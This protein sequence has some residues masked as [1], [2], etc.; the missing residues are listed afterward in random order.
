MYL[1]A[2][3][4]FISIHV[5]TIVT[6]FLAFFTI[7]H[8]LSSR[9]KPAQMIAWSVVIIFLPYFGVLIYFIFNRRRV[10]KSMLE[11]KKVNLQKVQEV[12]SSCTNKIEH[13]L[14]ESNIAGA[15]DKNEFY[16]FKDSKESYN[17]MIDLLKSAKSSIYICT[18]IFSDDYITKAIVKVLI[19][20]AKSGIEVKLLIDS[21]GSFSLELNPKILKNLKDVGGEYHFFMSMLRHPLKNRLNFR[22]HR[23]MV[24]VDNYTVISGGANISK[25]YLSDRESSLAWVDLLFMIKGSASFHYFEIFRYDWESQVDKELSFKIAKYNSNSSKSIIQ[26]VP[27]GLDVDNDALYESILYSLYLAKEKIWILT[28][29]FIPDSS[30]MDALVVAKHRGVDVKIILPKSSD[31]ILA[32]I[33]RSGYLRDLERESIEILLYGPKMLHAKAL[34]IDSEVAMV[35]SSNFDAR[36]FFYNFEV[37]SYLYS[38]DDIKEV[39][40]W[41]RRLFKD[42]K[43][44]LKPAKKIRIIFENFFKMFSLAL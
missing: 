31:Q 44:G 39:D 41:I 33:S 4:E 2:I 7:A 21:I 19:E 5:V 10:A 1:D 43:L 36:S 12:D 22:N 35:G 20:K 32:D 24:I 28:P 25:E 26:V 13:F 37:M 34:I 23:K 30:L 38:K 17:A 27:S 11:K 40:M 9:K 3:L 16:L 15:T 18:Y 42:C 8:M 14:R 6:L 29:Y